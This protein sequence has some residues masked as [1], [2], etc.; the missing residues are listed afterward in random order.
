MSN[1]I[2]AKIDLW[3]WNLMNNFVTLLFAGC[4][5][6]HKLCKNSQEIGREE[7]EGGYLAFTDNKIKEGVRK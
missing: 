4:K 5:D 1:N 7:V 2:C 3:Y 6:R